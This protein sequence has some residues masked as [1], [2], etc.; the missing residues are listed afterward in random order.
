MFTLSPIRKLLLLTGLLFIGLIPATYAE[1]L[2]SNTDD[3]CKI[4]LDSP[5]EHLKDNSFAPVRIRIEN[6]SNDRARHTVS[7]DS[8]DWHGSRKEVTVNIS[9][10]PGE[11]RQYIVY[12]PVDNDVD[13]KLDGVRK[14]SGDLPRKHYSS[15][16]TVAVQTGGPDNWNVLNNDTYRTVVC[17]YNLMD[18]PADY[19]MYCGLDTIIIP[20]KDY[21]TTLDELHRRALRQ[22]VMSGGHLWLTGDKNTT[23]A[24]TKLGQGLIVSM[25]SLAH[26]PEKQIEAQLNTILNNKK[27]FPA[28]GTLTSPLNSSP[29]G[30]PQVDV[31]AYLIS[32]PSAMIGLILVAFAIVVGPICLWG[33]APIGKRQRLFY[34]IPAISLAAFILL[35][36]GILITEGT[37]GTGAREVL[38]IVNQKDHSALILQNQVARTNIITNGNFTLPEDVMIYGHRLEKKHSYYSSEAFHQVDFK[39]VS[40]SGNA[41]TGDWF[42]GRSTVEHILKRSVTTRAA[43]TVDKDANGALMMQ[44]TFP[45]TLTNVIYRDA[46]SKLWHI[47]SLEPGAKKPAKPG[48]KPG[49]PIADQQAMQK[50]A[51]ESYTAKMAAVEE[52]ELGAIPTLPDIKWETTVITVQGLINTPNQ[53]TQQQ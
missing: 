4:F 52:A 34:L 19:R 27:I 42:P 23:P 3:P 24:S 13:Y 10:E 21:D 9:A 8:G 50:L 35:G 18:W 1:F 28:R 33:W 37:G 44:S 38:L 26:L 2:I 6:G 20:R 25:P 41:C 16:S 48:M 12:I 45:A 43:L 17:S 36:L 29:V 51:P 49:T 39:G 15:L 22:W 32:T 11:I 40:R 53:L 47:D 31:T 30:A 46:D 14:Y 5:Y 7:F